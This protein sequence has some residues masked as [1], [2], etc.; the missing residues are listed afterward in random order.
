MAE[1][2]RVYSQSLPAMK[3]VGRCYTEVD[4][5]NGTFANKWGEW[6]SK[7]LFE[8]LAYPGD[9]E[10][11]E[12]CNAFYGLCR[13]KEGE[14]FN[15]WIGAFLPPDAPVP[16]GYDSLDFDAGEIAVC[17]VYGKEPD[18]YFHC[19]FDR[20][21]EEGYEWTADKNGVRWMMERYTCPR[22]TQ[23]DD[24]GNVIL[25]MCFYTG[26]AISD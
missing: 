2:K 21:K 8:P 22:Y 20:L 14:E 7:G 24:E 15:Y 5:E 4:K 12:D 11:F 3:F 9:S 13:I 23:P 18:I 19:C 1:I 16:E 17:W 6:F 10:P 26:F 25:D